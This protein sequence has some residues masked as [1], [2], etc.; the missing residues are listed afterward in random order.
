MSV[1]CQIEPPLHSCRCVSPG[2]N[3]ADTVFMYC[4]TDYSGAQAVTSYT[5][6]DYT[7]LGTSVYPSDPGHSV[8][9]WFVGCN[10]TNALT[11]R[12]GVKLP[13]DTG[14]VTLSVTVGSGMPNPQLY[15]YNRIAQSNELLVTQGRLTFTRNLGD[16]RAAY[17]DTN[18]YVQA[19]LLCASNGVARVIHSFNT[20][21]EQPYP[22]A[23]CSKQYFVAWQICFE[24]IT[25]ENEPLVYNPCGIATNDIGLFWFSLNWTA[26]L[27]S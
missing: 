6:K 26:A 9:N 24:P 7:V 10:V 27:F 3:F 15:V 20:H 14:E 23:I 11:L 16:W 18:G 5:R 4:V 12:T 21:P 8:S 2:T 22:I 19:Y 25:S 13:G 1:I 17:C